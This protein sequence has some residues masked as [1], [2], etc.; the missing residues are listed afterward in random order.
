[1]TTST[2]VLARSV[3]SNRPD[4]IDVFFAHLEAQLDKSKE[5]K[6]ASTTFALVNRSIK[7]RRAAAAVSGVRRPQKRRLN[8]VLAIDLVLRRE[9][10]KRIDDDPDGQQPIDIARTIDENFA[11]LTRSYTQ[12]W[13]AAHNIRGDDEIA[14]SATASRNR[15]ETRQLLKILDQVNSSGEKI[16]NPTYVLLSR[17]YLLLVEMMQLARKARNVAI[18]K[19][20]T[21]Q[22]EL[23]AL[24]MAYYEKQFQYQVNRKSVPKVLGLDVN[25]KK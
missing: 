22:N 13:Y 24:Q 25:Y 12:R 11:N 5:D 23:K 17:N 9:L 4:Y 14:K 10:V 15:N 8:P 6:L 1:M 7:T 3:L 16:S 19:Y 2:E 21:L 18:D 20:W